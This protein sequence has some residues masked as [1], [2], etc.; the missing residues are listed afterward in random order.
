[1][2]QL[3]TLGAPLESSSTEITPPACN[4]TV[5]GV[6][7]RHG[8]IFYGGSADSRRDTREERHQ[9]ILS[10]R[11]IACPL[12]KTMFKFVGVVTVDTASRS[13]VPQR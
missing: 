1:M 2:G 9:P 3:Q 5:F 7:E 12:G 10:R 8:T 4:F 6:D 13:P 11:R